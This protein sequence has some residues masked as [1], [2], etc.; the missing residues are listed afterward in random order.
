MKTHKRPENENFS[1][2]LGQPSWPAKEDAN[3]KI[4]ELSNSKLSFRDEPQI[5]AR[6][7]RWD[8]SRSAYSITS[9]S[10]IP[11]ENFQSLQ[12][13]MSEK[14]RA[15]QEIEKIK[16]NKSLTPL[17]KQKAIRSVKSLTRTIDDLIYREKDKISDHFES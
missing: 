11:E 8:Q 13:L 7:S 16:R 14:E 4:E 1:P 12:G 5:K 9:Q 3:L 15:H 10:I 2:N 6:E 17:D